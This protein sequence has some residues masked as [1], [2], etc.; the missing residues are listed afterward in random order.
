MKKKIKISAVLLTLLIV[1][2]LSSCGKPE[3]E[4]TKEMFSKYSFEYFDTVTTIKGY[5]ESEEAF[6]EIAN[7]MLDELKEYHRLFTI[8]LSYEGL[9]NL[10]T[11][12][13]LTG[14][15]HLTV[16]VDRRIIDLLLYAKEMYRLTGGKMNVAMGSVLSIWHDYRTEG[17][18]DPENAEL[19]PPERLRAAAEH[20]DI[21]AIVID[22]EASTVTLT[23][24]KMKLDVGAIAKGYAVEMVARSLEARGVT[25]YIINVGG[26]VRTVGTKPDGSKWKVGIED[27]LGG[28]D[29]ISLVS[30]SGESLVTSGVYQRYYIVDG[31]KYHHIIDPETLMPAEGYAS[32]SV[33]TADSALGDALSTALM[34]MTVDEGTA[35]VES[36]DG[37]EAQWVF[38]D[39][40]RRASSGWGKYAN[41][42]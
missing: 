25:G 11:V 39:G 5:A 26:N 7:G 15:E 14:G 24:P 21:D 31:K 19:P 4:P 33:L 41:N 17:I 22:E 27:P 20:T 1:V 30:L 34:C 23:D 9:N 13:Q 38:P 18:D 16:T 36:L 35:L 3:T 29:Y 8:Y 40:T 6:D 28:D 2:V 12:N 10:R 32:V 42:K 37:V